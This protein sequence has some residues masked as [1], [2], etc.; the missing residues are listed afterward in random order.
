[1]AQPPHRRSW[2]LAAG[3]AAAAL[4]AWALVAADLIRCD[5]CEAA[6]DLRLEGTVFTQCAIA[7]S[8]TPQA[9]D[10]SITVG[11]AQRI[12]IG[13]VAQNCNR[14]Q[15]YILTVRSANCA[16]A[17]TG[18]KLVNPASGEY[19]AYSG[20]FNNPTTGGSQAVVTGLMAASCNVQVGRAVTWTRIRNETSTIY[21]NLT[22]DP[23]LGA[24]TYEDIVTI[25]LNM[26]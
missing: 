16:Q 4:G 3:I 20:E 12:M 14:R 8:A 15:S 17:P 7:V 11:G 10:I 2:T 9:A 13:S 24:G 23:A 25:A 21:V 5:I 19:L 18:A 6:T 1:M 26:Q 22:G